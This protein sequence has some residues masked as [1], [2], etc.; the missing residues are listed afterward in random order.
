MRRIARCSVA[1]FITWRSGRGLGRRWELR[2]GWRRRFLGH[3]GI[4]FGREIETC[5][6]TRS[7]ES[8]AKGCENDQKRRN[9]AEIFEI[10]LNEV[11]FVA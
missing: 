8:A 7:I 6:Q 4:G 1:I 3:F 11:A 9:L 2:A 5:E 10:K